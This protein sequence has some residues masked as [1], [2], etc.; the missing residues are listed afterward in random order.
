[1]LLCGL[2]HL[3]SESPERG[4][5]P[6]QTLPLTGASGGRTL[7]STRYSQPGEINKL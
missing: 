6:N 4:N 7:A 2:R 5:L 3:L 1:M